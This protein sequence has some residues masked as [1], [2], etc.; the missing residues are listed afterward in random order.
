MGEPLQTP[1]AQAGVF[2]LPSPRRMGISKEWSRAVLCGHWEGLAPLGLR[3]KTGSLEGRGPPG[4]AH[5]SP[6][7]PP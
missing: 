6:A 4:G 3:D 5:P 1:W 2:S 7:L